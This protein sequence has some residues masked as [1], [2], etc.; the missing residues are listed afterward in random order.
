M[1]RDYA[2]SAAAAAYCAEAAVF[3]AN[4]ASGDRVKRIGWRDFRRPNRGEWSS[5]GCRFRS[6][7]GDNIRGKC[8]DPAKSDLASLGHSKYSHNVICWSSYVA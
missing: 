7:V 5:L 1:D 2:P 8:C 4:V 6:N 3:A